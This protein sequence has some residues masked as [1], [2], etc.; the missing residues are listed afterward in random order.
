MPDVAPS[1]MIALAALATIL[2]AA[3]LVGGPDRS[4]PACRGCG[5]DARPHAWSDVPRCTC[6]LAL[7]R[8]GSV[9]LPRRR[10]I[11]YVVAAA[12]VGAAA[13]LLG[14]WTARVHAS[15]LGWT[16]ELPT[17]V[18]AATMPLRRDDDRVATAINR[19]IELGI[20]LGLTRD[21]GIELGLTRDHATTLLAAALDA[22]DQEP[23]RARTSLRFAVQ[24]LARLAAPEGELG[25][26][27]ASLFTESLDA[28]VSTTSNGTKIALAPQGRFGE[29]FA[30]ELLV[31]PDEVLVD[32]TAV[33]FRMVSG[34]GEPIAG[35]WC[36]MR[37]EGVFLMVDSILA[38]DASSV[39]VRG[40]AVLYGPLSPH[41]AAQL[42]AQFG[43]DPSAWGVPLA[44]APF[45]RSGVHKAGSWLPAWAASPGVSFGRW[46]YLLDPSSSLQQ[47][48]EFAAVRVVTCAI[49]GIVLGA[50]LA[51]VL[52]GARWLAR[53]RPRLARPRCAAC[54]AIVRG[55]ADAL[56]ERC[57]ECGRSLG[58]DRSVVW[59]PRTIRAAPLA[60]I[61][62]VALGGVAVAA[63]FDGPELLSRLDG[64]VRSRLATP[65][66]YARWVADACIG[67]SGRSTGNQGRTNWAWNS[68]VSDL[69]PDAAMASRR[70]EES[71][72]RTLG[73][74][75]RGIVE[76]WRGAPELAPDAPRH[77]TCE[78]LCD[79]ARIVK[80]AMDAD[81]IDGAEAAAA[82]RAM[83]D[84]SGVVDLVAPLCVRAGAPIPIADRN[85]YSGASV[86]VR[87]ADAERGAAPAWSMPRDLALTAPDRP[88]ATE[89]ALEWAVILPTMSEQF[90]P[91]PS[92][93]IDRRLAS[94]PLRGEFRSSVMVLAN[95]P[96]DILVT[97]PAL[98]PLA[99]PTLVE[100]VI[101][102][103]GTRAEFSVIAWTYGLGV[104]LRGAWIVELP[105]GPL[106]VDVR[107]WNSAAWS[108]LGMLP[109]SLP[110]ELTMRFVP[111]PTD[112]AWEARR[113]KSPGIVWNVPTD[114]RVRRAT[115]KPTVYWSAPGRIRYVGSLPPLPRR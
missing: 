77:V 52:G 19:R 14:L 3:W 105:D 59:T 31:R 103:F 100:F 38:T 88:G 40:D 46:A 96:G 97:D 16:G 48:F 108:A 90:E 84:A 87:R 1:L 61:V 67:A 2:I 89:V 35:R 25:R 20:E 36:A 10:S 104:T 71:A 55:G 63:A 22:C 74:V 92:D 23:S 47:P 106:H 93:E 58:F 13:A 79:L 4:R 15:G 5:A 51:V 94:L 24:A 50:V 72:A 86:F 81:A 112:A 82:I 107:T 85:S 113:A 17:W 68:R 91:L 11:R 9:R 73:L 62:V 70:D 114:V 69:M 66:T 39:L 45:Q 53:R 54:D 64:R 30:G 75:A 28:I 101:Q 65:E 43:D 99:P 8:P 27:C 41:A 6:G 44:R 29:S 102:P 78:A 110:D 7:D 49:A 95:E 12:I 33:P 57:S 21:Q 32:G 42:P 98:N 76:G 109:A 56:P 18:L 37:G 80:R 115:G 26:R 34:G 60:A 111:L 83:I